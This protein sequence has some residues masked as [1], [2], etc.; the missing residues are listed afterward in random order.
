[1]PFKTKIYVLFCSVIFIT[2]L[3]AYLSVNYVV[4]RH[5]QAS[6]T[7]AIQQQIAWVKEK[8]TS[9]IQQ[10]ILLAA[11]LNFGVTNVK[12][13]LEET[14]FYNIVKVIG[15]MAFDGGGVIEDASRVQAL[16]ELIPAD[17]KQVQVSPILEEDGK[18]LVRILVP[19]GA[20]SA[21]FFYLD[22]TPVK[23]QLAQASQHGSHFELADA[24]GTLLFSDHPDADLVPQSQQIEVQGNP[25]TLTGYVDLD[26]I[27][28]IT[29]GLNRTITLSLVVAG[30]LI[31]LI[32]VAA[33][34]V[35]Y[36]PIISLRDLVLDL[37]RGSGD[38]TRRLAVTSDDDLGQIGTG[39]NRFIEQ[40]Q[41][42]MLEVRQA[43]E[44]LSS[45][46]QQLSQ[47]TDTSQQLLDSHVQETDLVVTAITQMSSTAN[48]VAENAAAT[49]KL[50]QETSEQAETSRQVVNIAIDSVSALVDEVEGTA[51][52][53]QTMQ[54]DA[55]QIGSILGVI[56][57]IAEQTNLLAL[58]AAIEA[59]RAGDL[60]RGFAVVADEVRALAARTQSS[61][62][63]IKEMLTRLQQG[64]GT[65]VQSMDA[66]KSSCLRTADNTRQVT[67]SLDEMSTHI[68]EIND[69]S[70]M[71]ATAAEQQRAVTDE[72]S[73]NM[74]AIKE[75]IHHLQGNGDA[76]VASTAGIGET[77]RQ[78][79]QI[80]ERFKL[81]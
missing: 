36:R 53:I 78:L 23:E 47:Q 63:E 68:V 64:T 71:M 8:L 11:N 43:S 55:E 39:I 77:Y 44:R 10:K 65:V 9:D 26:Y 5:I 3:T 81:Q 4:S 70:S 31:M 66:T 56:G 30:I 17:S 75:V 20:D 40:L 35:A 49:A 45:G 27:H 1:M 32:S 60:G 62:L 18:P 34:R 22:L 29:A 12:K 67:H 46:I 50:T 14:G 54:R 38:L 15:D 59:A 2:V 37:S 58:N 41:G 13:T 52:S 6:Q 25:W 80:V 7:Q 69:L 42:M 61:T 79:T 57:G 21:Y 28:S 74:N 72:I 16:R 76:T 19:R 33:T 24:K 73:R 51:S 48:S